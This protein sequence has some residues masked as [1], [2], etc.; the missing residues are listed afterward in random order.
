MFNASEIPQLH[1]VGVY[2]RILQE[3]D[4]SE[5]Y[6]AWLN[7][8]EITR[9]LEVRF[10]SMTRESIVDDLRTSPDRDI[11]FFGI[12]QQGSNFH[13][14]NIRL[15]P[16]NQQHARAGIGIVVGERS[17]WGR[18]VATEA[19]QLI[20]DFGFDSLKLEKIVAGIYEPNVGSTKAFLKAGFEIEATLPNYWNCGDE[21]VGEVLLGKHRQS[22]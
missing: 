5:S 4:V 7:D 12:F 11:Y 2:L 1:G 14:G 21:R 18:G 6:V 16:V 19:I 8:L 15:G 22:T 13:L 3:S 10:R 20:S 9:Y 17:A